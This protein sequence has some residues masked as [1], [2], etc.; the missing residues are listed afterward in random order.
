MP[1]KQ[2]IGKLGEQLAEKHLIN[3]GFLIIGRNYRVRGGEIDLICRQGRQ[4][5]F[6]EVKTRTSATFGYP[7]EALTFFKK[8]RI[9][10]AILRYLAEQKR[11]VKW[12][13]DLIAIELDKISK[14]AQLRHYPAIEL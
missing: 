3:K 5:F 8:R 13:A 14:K 4:Y 12:Q 1:Y 9:K 2:Q 11:P 10:T 7:E 6:I